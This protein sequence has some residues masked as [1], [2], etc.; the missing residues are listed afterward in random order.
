MGFFA[1]P[2]SVGDMVLVRQEDSGFLR[3]KIIYR[4]DGGS[5]GGGPEDVV[6]SIAEDL[7]DFDERLWAPIKH[8]CEA[9]AKKKSP[10]LAAERRLIIDENR[11]L[12]AL[13][14]VGMTGR[15]GHRCVICGGYRFEGWDR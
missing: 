14:P 11:R 6:H 3:G 1:G 10:T 7:A 8:H 2:T 4:V 9:C 5:G 15:T 12:P 13:G